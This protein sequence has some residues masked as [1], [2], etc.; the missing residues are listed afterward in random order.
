MRGKA[1][2]ENNPTV[3][4]KAFEKYTF[5]NDLYQTPDNPAFE[6]FYLADAEGEFWSKT[7]SPEPFCL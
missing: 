7:E 3:K 4:K 1:V 5:F 2:Y 6:V